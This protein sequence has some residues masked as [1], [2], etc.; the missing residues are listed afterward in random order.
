MIYSKLNNKELASKWFD[1]AVNMNQKNSTCFFER[2][3]F[4]C[5]SH[6]YDSAL[7]DLNEAIILKPND[8]DFYN[9]RGIV[10]LA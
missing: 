5:H 9:E 7:S 3:K 4:R 2:G 6:Q 8:P 10:R 1:E